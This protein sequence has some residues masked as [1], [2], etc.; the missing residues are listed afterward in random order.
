MI[1]IYQNLVDISTTFQV[2]SKNGILSPL[3]KKEEF[4]ERSKCFDNFFI[5]H[6][7]S[8]LERYMTTLSLCD[9]IHFISKHSKKELL[10][11]L[12]NK[13][14]CMELSFSYY[15]KYTFS[16]EGIF[17]DFKIVTNYGEDNSNL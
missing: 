16:Y 17:E 7:S 11:F 1:W 14:D 13:F 4:I 12:L 3:T 6:C 5:N 8:L 2:E 10:D 15:N 9:L